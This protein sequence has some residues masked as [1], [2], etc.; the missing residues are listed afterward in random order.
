MC[1]MSIAHSTYMYI[2]IS[3]GSYHAYYGPSIA[4]GSGVIYHYAV[5]STFQN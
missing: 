1:D 5:S 3:D 4:L 2:L